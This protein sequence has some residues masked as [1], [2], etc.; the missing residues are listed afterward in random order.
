MVSFLPYALIFAGGVLAMINYLNRWDTYK[1]PY[2]RWTGL[3]L[4]I[5]IPLGTAAAL[6]H[7]ISVRDAEKLSLESEKATSE[8]RQSEMRFQGQRDRAAIERLTNEVFDL[9]LEVKSAPLLEKLSS[10]ESA[11]A[12]TKKAMQ[13]GPKPKVMYTLAPFVR[14]SR[15]EILKPVTRTSKKVDADDRIKVAFSGQNA[16][17]VS[18]IGMETR[19]LICEACEFASETPGFR[20]VQ[21]GSDQQRNGEGSS[22]PMAPFAEFTFDIRVPKR[23]KAIQIA[24]D[25]SC[26]NCVYEPTPQ[27][28][29][30]DLER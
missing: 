22:P 3:F 29:T 12:D 11:L 4:T 14:L 5:G 1:N 21:G 2:F 20:K 28:F 30:V 25:H 18:A 24:I 9:K 17:T 13:P 23:A 27:V 6:S 26:D 8:A 16:S 10:V 15:D 7:E 19:V